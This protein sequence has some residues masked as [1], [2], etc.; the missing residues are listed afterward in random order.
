MARSR[1]VGE[2]NAYD[3]TNGRVYLGDLCYSWG[4]GDSLA[5]FTLGGTTA[6]TLSMDGQI[7]IYDATPAAGSSSYLRI[8]LPNVSG[9]FL[10]IVHFKMTRHIDDTS[11]SNINYFA[12]MDAT[13]TGGLGYNYDGSTPTLYRMWSNSVG[14]GTL[15]SIAYPLVASQEYVF[16]IVKTPSKILFIMNNVLVSS[17]AVSVKG[18]SSMSLTPQQSWRAMSKYLI[19]YISHQLN[20]ISHYRVREIRVSKLVGIGS[21]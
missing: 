12:I 9:E 17:L 4:L 14:G 6:P 8:L 1:F 20:Q 5:A 15:G 10:S 16:N 2:A 11:L 19:F 13:T 3:V 7:D 18:S 21:M